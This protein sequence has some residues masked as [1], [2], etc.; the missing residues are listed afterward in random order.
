MKRLG[1]SGLTL[2]LLVYLAP[3]LFADGLIVL[4]PPPPHRPPYTPLAIKY[5]RVSVEIKDGIA[6]TH[7]DQV[8]HNPNSMQL[9]GTYIFPIP[10]NASISRFSMYIDGEETKAELLD[11]DKARKIYEDIV[12]RTRDPAI[13]EYFG[14]DAFRARVFPIPPRGDKRIKLTYSEILT[15]DEGMYHYRYPL[16]TER[17]SSA[18]I[19]EVSIAVNIQS[20]I[21]IANVYSPSH[22]IDVNRKGAYEAS[23]SFE[24]KNVKPDTDFDLFYTV[25]EREFGV[26]L[27]S[28]AGEG[29]E[30]GYFLLMFAPKIDIKPDRVVEK[31]IVLV[32]DTSGSMKGKKIE[33]AKSALWF[34]TQSLN[35]GDRF[36]LITFATDVRTLFDDSSGDGP[37][38]P[39]NK[40]NVNAAKEFIDRIE[41][42][43]G[44]NMEAAFRESLALAKSAEEGRPFIIVFLTD[45]RPTVGEADE[46]T[47]VK[48]ISHWKTGRPRL[49]V[50][51]V[52]NDVNTHFLDEISKENSGTSMYVRER[53]DLEVKVSSFYTKIAS[54]VLSEPKYEISGIKIYDTYPKELPDFFKG[55]EVMVLGRY[56][57]AGSKAIRLT[58]MVGRDK[59]EY[60]YEGTFEAEKGTNDFLPRLWATRKIGYLLGEIRLHSENK[61]LVDEVVR[62]SKK[63]GIM[64]PYTSYLVLEDERRIQARGG[65]REV[66]FRDLLRAPTESEWRGTEMAREAWKMP[67]GAP[68]M[69]ASE[70]LKNMSIVRSLSPE[71]GGGG[72]MDFAK[73]LIK[74]IG[75]KSFYKSDGKW[76]DS[77]YKSKMKTE[78]ITFMS[79]EYF[80]LLKKHP[81]AGKYFA[82]GDK[83]I[84]V[85]EGKAYKVTPEK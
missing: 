85:L 28:Y 66:P 5:H 31:D 32:I 1:I 19:K 23:C 58:G 30:D 20:K 33:Q 37:L 65:R 80:E 39:A 56:S 18:P 8:F 12:R 13:L 11:R 4:P 26:N 24:Q 71:M 46:K 35:P 29:G 41:A 48:R 73:K 49:F 55:S 15:A 64:T 36:N 2:I 77:T 9:E 75:D 52:G 84:V 67:A 25:S 22:K 68:A 69:K 14:R 59:K 62:L 44:T 74:N 63:Y 81:E 78:K 57:G 17:F 79:D 83:V 82:L 7:I 61:E 10:E 16:N 47:L 51:G 70:D 3:I 6:F 72:R 34:C 53:E 21:S 45:G 40:E 54:P 42:V 76:V 60:A 43:G 38:M 50:F 27:I